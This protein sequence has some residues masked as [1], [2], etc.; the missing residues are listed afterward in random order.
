LLG[1]EDGECAS[2]GHDDID[3]ERNQFGRENG[4]PLH[5][6]LRPAVF[7]QDVTVLD[8]TELTQSLT[9]RGHIRCARVGQAAAEEADHRHRLLLR[10][11]HERPRCSN[12]DQLDELAPSH[13]F[14]Q[15][16]LVSLALC[17]EAVER[18]SVL[19]ACQTLRA[20]VLTVLGAAS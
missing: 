8:V 14:P 9:K 13:V 20:R 2:G 5:L 10:A 3:P 11:R 1:G 17:D 15:N 16:T 6:P 18:H 4:E 12:S 19:I 7:D